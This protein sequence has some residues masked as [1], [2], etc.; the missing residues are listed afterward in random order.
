[1]EQFMNMLVVALLS[2]APSAPARTAVQIENWPA[3]KIT[4]HVVSAMPPGCSADGSGCAVVN[5]ADRTCDVYIAWREPQKAVLREREL[6]RCRG[7][8]EPPYRLRTAYA[9]WLAGQPCRSGREAD[10]RAIVV[11]AVN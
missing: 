7:V 3:L 10:A 8:D 1:M 2:M 4:E 5:F 6:R 9:Q 11:A